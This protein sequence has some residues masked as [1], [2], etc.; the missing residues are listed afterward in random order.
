MRRVRTGIIESADLL[1]QGLQ[2]G[3][4]RYRASFIRL[5]YRDGV[6]PKARHISD[7]LKRA[8]Q[9]ALR[10]GGWLGHVYRY[11][12]GSERGRGHYHVIVWLPRGVTMPRWDTRGWWPHGFTN[13]EWARK[14]VKYIAKYASKADAVPNPAFLVRGLRWWGCGGLNVLQRMRLRWRR[15]PQWVRQLRALGGDIVQRLGGGW[16][17]I[18][19]WQVRAPWDFLGLQPGG[20]VRIAPRVWAHDDFVYVGG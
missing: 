1:E 17:R 14:P 8:R 2:E 13:T 6:R 11:E 7:A 12:F 3:G 4:V 20:G 5:S 10:H 19:P 15:A 16:W 18:G 9:W